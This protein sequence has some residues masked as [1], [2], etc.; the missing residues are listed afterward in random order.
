MKH[1]PMS[2]NHINMLEWIS[3]WSSHTEFELSCKDVLQV[4][5]EINFFE[6]Q[7]VENK[8]QEQLL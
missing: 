2:S 6:M 1:N 7:T 8:R 3:L 5:S 4:H